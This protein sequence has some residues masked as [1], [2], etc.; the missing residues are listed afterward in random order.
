MQRLN[1]E[2]TKSE[3]KNERQATKAGWGACKKQE[4]TLYMADIL[5][6]QRRKSTGRIYTDLSKLMAENTQRQEVCVGK[7]PTK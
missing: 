7:K 5:T 3:N 1:G 4:K 2:K 6:C